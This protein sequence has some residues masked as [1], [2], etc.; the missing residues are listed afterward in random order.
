MHSNKT[1]KY[2]HTLSRDTYFGTT[3]EPNTFE[4]RKTLFTK[5]ESKLYGRVLYIRGVFADVLAD[6]QEIQIFMD[7]TIRRDD[8]GQNLQVGC[9]IEAKGVYTYSTQDKL[10]FAVH[11]WKIITSNFTP[12]KQDSE[13]EQLN[14]LLRAVRNTDKRRKLL[15]SNE[16]SLIISDI[17]Q[18]SGYIATI[19][20]PFTSKD[21]GTGVKPMH[22]KETRRKL[23]TDFEIETRAYLLLHP[24]VYQLGHV[25]RNEGVSYKNR[26]EFL[27]ANVYW[28][29]SSIEQTK[30]FCTHL[31][32]KVA[33]KV[34][35]SIPKISEMLF[36]EFIENATR[37]KKDPSNFQKHLHNNEDKRNIEIYKHI[38]KRSV[39][40]PVLVYGYPSSAL[41]FAKEQTAHKN[42]AQDFRI[43]WQGR[44]IIHGSLEINEYEEQVDRYLKL[45]GANYMAKISDGERTYLELLTYGIPPFAGFSISVDLLTQLLLGE[46]NVNNLRPTII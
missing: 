8:R 45:Y 4:H 19:T 17:L 21:I 20:S 9:I 14:Q 32:T 38:A 31:L 13:N 1:E 2:L 43:L 46:E 25:Y 26:Q 29:Y 41:P 3:G 35:V 44:T 5:H 27:Y 22:I 16:I 24:K 36:V 23:R 40:D 30:N 7:S 37:N 15:L 42:M 6:N 12:L 10:I 11:K 18:K 33:L 39:T 34:G 28:A